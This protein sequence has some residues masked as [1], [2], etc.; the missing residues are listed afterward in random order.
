[1]SSLSIPEDVIGRIIK[2]ISNI[3][4]RF[5]Y[6]TLMTS[7]RSDI[8]QLLDGTMSNI[9]QLF[10]GTMSAIEIYSVKLK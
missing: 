2:S 9:K 10:D 7:L 3:G 5:N 6:P 1:M 8:K 4:Y